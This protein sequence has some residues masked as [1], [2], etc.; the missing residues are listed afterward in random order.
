M[1]EQ[2]GIM[3]YYAP[4]IIISKPRSQDIFLWFPQRSLRDP[5]SIWPRPEASENSY[6]Y[7][8]WTISQVQLFASCFACRLQRDFLSLSLDMSLLFN[9]RMRIRVGDL[10]FYLMA[11]MAMRY[12]RSAIFVLFIHLQNSNFKPILPDDGPRHGFLPRYK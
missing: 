6:F 10:I 1:L 8:A 12:I 2:Q 4:L 7:S 3:G 9:C 11:V 5:K